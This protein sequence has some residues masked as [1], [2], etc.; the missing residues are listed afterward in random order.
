MGSQSKDTEMPLSHN[1]SKS[2]FYNDHEDHGSVGA[3]LN[4]SSASAVSAY[5]GAVSSPYS[6]QT[7]LLQQSYHGSPH[8]Q[9]KP[10]KRSGTPAS[11]GQLPGQ[12]VPAVSVHAR[13]S[14]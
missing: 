3:I 11:S 14:V 4:R 2:N 10:V 1:S 12:T 7:R 5:T 13:L 8:I 9:N 6:G